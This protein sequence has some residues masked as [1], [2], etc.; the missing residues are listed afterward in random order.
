MGLKAAACARPP[1]ASATLSPP[2]CCATIGR[3]RRS[4]TTCG[5]SPPDA[6]PTTAYRCPTSFAV[7]SPAS[8]FPWPASAAAPTTSGTY[9]PN[10]R[11]SSAKLDL[12]GLSLRTFLASAVLRQTE[13]ALTW[14]RLVTP[15]GRW[16]WVLAM[17]ARPTGAPGFGLW[18]TPTASASAPAAWKDGVPWWKQSRAARGLAAAVMWPTPTRDAATNRTKPYAQGGTSL[19]LAVQ[20]WATPTARDWRTA[21]PADYNR[22]NPCLPAQAGGALNPVFVE[23]LMGFPPDWTN[24]NGPPNGKACPVSPAACP[25][26]L[27]ACDA[28]ATPLCPRSSP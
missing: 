27:T 3:I 24:T 28:S 10:S 20:T 17:P 9:G 11:A 21:A 26:A 16:W 1:S 15:A 6:L 4:M 8:L 2:A 22:N 14:K 19:A 18:P 5:T 12:L 7:A 13:S 23:W 25:S